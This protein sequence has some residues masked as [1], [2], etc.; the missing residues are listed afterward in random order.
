MNISIGTDIEEVA[1]F[2]GKTLN[3]DELFFKKVYTAREVEYCFKHK[4]P[5]LHLCAR[6]CAKEAV[7]KALSDFDVKDVYYSDIEI[8]NREDG[9]PYVILNKYPDLKIKISLSHCKT[10]ATATA[11]VYLNSF[12]IV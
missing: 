9:S 1:R 6:Y 3:N 12:N 11:L 10:Y 7:V 8:L 4:Y 5:S 2:E